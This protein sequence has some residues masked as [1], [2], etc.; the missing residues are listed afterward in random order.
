VSV[1]HYSDD[2]RHDPETRAKVE[3][4]L[5]AQRDLLQ[6]AAATLKGLSDEMRVLSGTGQ[7]R[8]IYERC[9]D[10]VATA[11]YSVGSDAEFMKDIGGDTYIGN[12]AASE[13][14]EYLENIDMEAR[15]RGHA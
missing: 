5:I 2:R 8:S 3:R 1:Y 4:V 12:M 15:F 6:K 9:F 10:K 14:G 13:M 7:T 11:S